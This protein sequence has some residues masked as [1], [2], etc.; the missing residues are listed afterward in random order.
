MALYTSCD[1]ASKLIVGSMQALERRIMWQWLCAPHAQVSMNILMYGGH[2]KLSAKKFRT[3]PQGVL[4]LLNPQGDIT[5]SWG[6]DRDVLEVLKLQDVE[7]KNLL[8]KIVNIRY[9]GRYQ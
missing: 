9:C 3:I 4:R 5:D 2:V 1:A 7:A 8:K 6:N